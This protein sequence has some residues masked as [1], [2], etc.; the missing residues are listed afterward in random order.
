MNN[1]KNTFIEAFKTAFE[2]EKLLKLTLSKAIDKNNELKNVYAR[3][4]FIKQKFCIS[5]IFRYETRDETKN[6]ELS[7]AC[8]QLSEWLENDFAIATLAC[9]DQDTRWEKTAKKLFTQ[10]PTQNNPNPNSSHNQPKNYLIAENSAF[11]IALGISSKQGKVHSA[12]QHKF[13]QINKYVEIV[14]NLVEKDAPLHILDMGSGKGYLTFALYDYFKIQKNREISIK[15]VELRAHLAD[16]CNNTAEQLGWSKDI[17]FITSDI[18]NVDTQNTNILIALHACDT[19]TDL[20]IAKGITA[21]ADYIIVAPCC[22]K[23]L[24]KEMKNQTILQNVLKNGILQ[25][26]Q[27]E[28]LTDGIRA[29]IL[30]NQGY[31]TKIFEFIDYEHTSKNLMIT[32]H[33]LHQ[34]SNKNEAEIEQIKQLFGFE[35]HYLETLLK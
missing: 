5:W 20:A 34:K 11:L 18:K 21:Q 1:L 27:A 26:R 23:Q 22:Q 13:R 12:Q 19:A 28:I 29:L 6:T 2:E 15:G 17:N 4:V 31:Q 7:T 3:K 30:E 10:K 24:R 9:T 25:E 35:T 16:F 33:K 8:A 14:N 32:A